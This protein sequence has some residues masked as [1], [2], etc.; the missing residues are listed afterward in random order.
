MI[1][2]YLAGTV[3]L[4]VFAVV[5]VG[6]RPG[7]VIS[8][9]LAGILYAAL[10]AV[11]AATVRMLDL[12]GLACAGLVQQPFV[13]VV[14]IGGVLIT[15]YGIVFA[16][17][18]QLLDRLGNA[19][20]IVVLIE[21]SP[22][23]AAGLC[24]TDGEASMEMRWGH[25]ARTWYFAGGMLLTVGLGM[26]AGTAATILLNS[27][28]SSQ[29]AS[30][31]TARAVSS[32]VSA[33]RFTV[34]AFGRVR[35]V[36]AR[37]RTSRSI[38]SAWTGGEAS[39]DLPPVRWASTCPGAC[40]GQASEAGRLDS[41]GGTEESHDSADTK[42]GASVSASSVKVSQADTR[43]TPLRLSSAA[44][45]QATGSASRS[46]TAKAPSVSACAPE[47]ASDPPPSPAVPRLEHLSCEGSPIESP[48]LSPAVALPFG[49]DGEEVDEGAWNPDGE[50]CGGF[51][52]DTA[53]ASS[54]HNQP[55]LKTGGTFESAETEA[56][57][58]T[59]QSYRHRGTAFRRSS[60]RLPSV[61]YSSGLASLRAPGLT[62]RAIAAL[63]Q[64]DEELSLVLDS[65]RAARTE[66][67]WT[68]IPCR[69]WDGL[70]WLLLCSCGCI[71]RPVV[72]SDASDAASHGYCRCCQDPV[73]RRSGDAQLLL[74]ARMHPR[75]AKLNAVARFLAGAERA[76]PTSRAQARIAARVGPALEELV[77]A[78]ESALVVA[79]TGTMS[80][81]YWRC[82]CPCGQGAAS[83]ASSARGAAGSRP[84]GRV[85]NAATAGIP[86][87][88]CAEEQDLLQAQQ[89][90]L[91]RAAEA[92]LEAYTDA[93]QT[94][95]YGKRL[96]GGSEPDLER[97]ASTPKFGT[98]RSSEGA[99]KDG[100]HN[101]DVEHHGQASGSGRPN[102]WTVT[103]LL[104]ISAFIFGVVRVAENCE[105]LCEDAAA[106]LR[107]SERA[108]A[109][110]AC[111]ARLRA[112]ISAWN[113][114]AASVWHGITA[115]STCGIVCMHSRDGG[116]CNCCSCPRRGCECGCCGW[117][118]VPGPSWP[119]A[120]RAIKVALAIALASLLAF[121]PP[122]VL[123]DGEVQQGRVDWSIWTPLTVAF[124]F[125]SA[126]GQSVKQSM[127]RLGG[128]V[129]GSIFAFLL[130]V[131]ANDLW[132]VVVAGLAVWAAVV[133]PARLSQ[134]TGYAGAV[135]IF[136]AA[137]VAVGE[138][139]AGATVSDAALSRVL[140][141]F[142]GVGIFLLVSNTLWPN[143][144]SRATLVSVA[145]AIS[146]AGDAID[147]ATR[148]FLRAV[149]IT[150]AP[151]PR[152]VPRHATDASARAAIVVPIPALGSGHSANSAVEPIQAPHRRHGSSFGGAGGDADL[153]TV[154]VA[155]LSSRVATVAGE[156]DRQLADAAN[157]V[158]ITSS[159]AAGMGA[160]AGTNRHLWKLSRSIRCIN[161]C[162]LALES[163]A[164]HTPESHRAGARALMELVG[165][166]SRLSADIR[167]VS[168]LVAGSLA[169]MDPPHMFDCQCLRIGCRDRI[170]QAATATGSSD[171]RSVTRAGFQAATLTNRL[172]RLEQA[173]P[174]ILSAV[175]ALD[176]KF[177]AL[178]YELSLP[179]LIRNET[180]PGGSTGIPVST[181]EA[182][183]FSSA[184]FALRDTSEALLALAAT[185][186]LCSA[187][188]YP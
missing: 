160:L 131:I 130:V 63:Q 121:S 6:Q 23:F 103:E 19:V 163:A 143:H 71:H 171:A 105:G 58:D 186:E 153:A 12:T 179:S 60:R 57:G 146:D 83:Q 149:A 166:V 1:L 40:E 17:A 56:R 174:A 48:A 28:S 119:R 156:L 148:G 106:M 33:V 170:T 111:G 11:I 69:A 109:V 77:L 66:Q 9:S 81:R 22:V 52:G 7:D 100:G 85:R 29:E 75:L 21:R 129:G 137:I 114:T 45:V 31:R 10:A 104:P 92:V 76:A 132:P 86:T 16:Q 102:D 95:L 47:L 150:A 118:A 73:F 79:A 128:T 107:E 68:G 39:N 133:S 124:V 3:L 169:S 8:T 70:L 54:P 55:P 88:R 135:A 120:R 185:T 20:S 72:H 139:E 167:R 173:V 176:L 108:L 5:V 42:P 122:T 110:P 84:T 15:A 96:A 159:A 158:G 184:I 4:P 49:M 178:T 172:R 117:R 64:G 126:S 61:A 82:W 97:S 38:R 147:V 136:T 46:V 168:G 188:M 164:R 94:V 165:P 41:S 180:E 43:V 90:R 155:A 25:V 116:A 67:W 14:A 27:H 175:V 59:P 89:E 113:A 152:S 187:L 13:D 62:A 37:Q 123:H 141:N 44:A 2:Q 32:I 154:T 182:V 115:S 78:A 162:R 34:R 125:M 53:P 65:I 157:E 50:T 24:P 74:T 127:L 93:R 144:G 18:S 151:V 112:G 26:A 36:S 140:Q 91:S 183:G 35:L 138:R 177:E 145:G 161:Q 98:L 134:R 87:S 99:M 101:G 80:R 142:V 30:Q 181:V 51:P